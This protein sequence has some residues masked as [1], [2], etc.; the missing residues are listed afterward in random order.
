MI[1]TPL[2][3]IRDKVNKEYCDDLYHV[4]MKWE[5]SYWYDF[6]E[7]EE[8]DNV[9][10]CGTVKSCIP[11]IKK[12]IDWEHYI[13]ERST[14]MQDINQVRMFEGDVV[15]FWLDYKDIKYTLV[16]EWMQW[17]ISDWANLKFVTDWKDLE[18]VWNIHS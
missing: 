3:R 16:Y 15:T 1:T 4:T 9:W 2:Y 10:F 7:E 8:Y 11:I 13:I 12:V 6:W 14:G 5:I 18:V 17:K